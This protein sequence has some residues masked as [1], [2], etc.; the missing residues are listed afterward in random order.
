MVFSFS[1]QFCQVRG[2]STTAVFSTSWNRSQ[3]FCQV[4]GGQWQHSVYHGT[5]PR[6]LEQVPATGIR[7]NLCPAKHPRPSS[8][9]PLHLSRLL[10]GLLVIGLPLE[11]LTVSRKQCSGRLR[12][13]ES[14][15]VGRMLFPALRC[16]RL[17]ST[18][19]NIYIY[20]YI[21]YNS[22]EQFIFH[23]RLGH[24]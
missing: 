8:L 13:S 16:G 19:V 22:C 7:L 12:A 9:T 17:L 4:R 1:A 18:E 11:W 14:W 21:I 23:L 3:Q 15:A 2:R 6:L 5:G 10:L 20:V 24:I